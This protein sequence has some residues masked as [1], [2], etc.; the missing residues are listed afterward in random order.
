MMAAC[1]DPPQACDALHGQVTAVAS[2]SRLA[3]V[4]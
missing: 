3:D 1:D 4:Y 2:P